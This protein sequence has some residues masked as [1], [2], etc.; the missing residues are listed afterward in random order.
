MRSLR[1]WNPRYVTNRLAQYLYK[2]D[3]KEPMPDL[4]MGAIQFLDG[5]LSPT[6]KMMEYGAGSSTAWFARRV[7]ELVSIE[8]SKKWFD[9]V[10]G[11][12]A[13]CENVDLKLINSKENITPIAN[14][15]FEY[16]EQI[17]RYG[18]EYFDFVLDDGYA[19]PLVALESIKYLKKGGIFA[20]DDWA[21]S[22][23]VK[24]THVPR[25]LPPGAEVG[26]LVIDFL[27]AVKDWRSMVFDDGTHT[28]AFFFKPVG[29]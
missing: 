12:I 19:R 11:E 25:A 18:K 21:G 10:T 24:G 8:N 29:P 20:W 3:S 2:S 7:G 16:V 26:S 23:P 27:E 1:H 4:A 13:A 6:D 14:V 28:T 17:Q 22:Y 9:I 5:W 15:S